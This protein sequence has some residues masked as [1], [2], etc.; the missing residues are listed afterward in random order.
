MLTN[1][2]GG[3]EDMK[4]LSRLDFEIVVPA[5]EADE[6]D[7]IELPEPRRLVEVDDAPPKPANPW[8]LFAARDSSGNRRPVLVIFESHIR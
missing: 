1:L 6:A 8:L 5:S 7:A 2:G 4:L 3:P